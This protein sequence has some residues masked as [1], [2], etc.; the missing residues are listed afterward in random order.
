MCSRHSVEPEMVSQQ[1]RWYIKSSFSQTWHW[2]CTRRKEPLYW[3][4]SKLRLTNVVEIFHEFSLV[5][6]KQVS[7]GEVLCQAGHLARKRSKCLALAPLVVRGSQLW[8]GAWQEMERMGTRGRLSDLKT[9]QLLCGR[10]GGNWVWTRKSRQVWSF[11]FSG[12]RCCSLA[13]KVQPQGCHFQEVLPATTILW[14]YE[15]SLQASPSP[16]PLRLRMNVKGLMQSWSK[17]VSIL[18][19]SPPCSFV[20]SHKDCPDWILNTQA[21]FKS[22]CHHLF[23]LC[24]CFLICKMGLVP[25]LWDYSE[26]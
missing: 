6:R 5:T 1:C 23:S 16:F 3:V 20:N 11:F 17:W 2:I 4:I 8:S 10:R 18:V 13:S 19:H 12:F 22:G 14:A 25:I 26:D 24:L 21:G 9:S 7:E 15:L